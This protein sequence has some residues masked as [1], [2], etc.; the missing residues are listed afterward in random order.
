MR[1]LT[2]FVRENK[3]LLRDEHLHDTRVIIDG[4]NFFH[5]TY[6]SLIYTKDC[7]DYNHDKYGGDYDVY[8]DILRYVFSAFKTCHIVPYV[9]LDGGFDKKKMATC[10]KRTE[11]RVEISSL[12]A[13]GVVDRR[14]RLLPILASDTFMC[15]LKEMNIDYY[16]CDYEADPEMAA[17]AWEWKCPVLTNDS[18]FFIYDLE[19]GCIALDDLHLEIKT[20]K[21]DA[22][23]DTYKYLPVKVYYLNSFFKNIILIDKRQAALL[24]TLLGNDYVNAHVFHKFYN[25]LFSKLPPGKVKKIFPLLQW[26]Q[27]RTSFKKALDDLYPFLN[28]KKATIN[29]IMQS[30]ASYCDF[31]NGLG[32]DR[33]MPT[34]DLPEWFLEDGDL[35]RVCVNI[36]VHHKVMLNSQVEEADKPSSYLCSQYL[37]SIMYGILLKH[38]KSKRKIVQ[39]YDRKRY[40]EGYDIK[41]YP[42]EYNR[43]RYP[44]E[45]DIKRYPREYDMERYPEQYDIEIYPKECDI[46][47]DLC[48]W[49]KVK[50]LLQLHSGRYVPSL[51]QIPHIM[52]D[53]RITFLLDALGIINH[54][55]L[56]DMA[57]ESIIFSASLIYWMKNSR[58]C[59]SVHQIVALITC[60]V[61]LSA[62]KQILEPRTGTGDNQK[63][64]GESKDTMKE[65]NE[66]IYAVNQ[67]QTCLQA[68]LFLNQILRYPFKSCSPAGMI[69]GTTIY[70]L[71]RMLKYSRPDPVTYVNVNILGT[72][73]KLSLYFQKLYNA[74]SDYIPTDAAY[75][76][77]D[78]GPD[79]DTAATVAEV[80]INFHF[81]MFAILKDA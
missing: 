73:T 29:Q 47:R 34:S 6:P 10:E 81:Y 7:L 76:P 4:N 46:K 70:N 55:Q 45:Y 26:L 49:V 13:D 9:I 75:I 19:A 69:S 28:N 53:D 37:R 31:E 66:N 52:I 17:L 15:V 20:H 8:A 11:D 41:R 62:G 40:P 58:P 71:N 54:K 5:F 32:S 23:A 25:H 21:P 68:A 44:K 39:E 50:P 33:S 67:F 27:S 60:F 22:S 74:I 12:M 36:I 56:C 48:V 3:H 72:D 24:A 65:D 38:G 79:S 1:G 35:P 16:R 61:K 64:G 30:V 63:E 59:V 42:E 80:C 51:R 14:N 2:A 57:E 18:D 77:T 43:T 78:A